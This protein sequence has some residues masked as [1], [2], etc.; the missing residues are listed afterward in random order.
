MKVNGHHFCVTTDDK[1]HPFRCGV[2]DLP[3]LQNFR[4]KLIGILMGS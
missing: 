4:Q 1:P 2:T 3:S